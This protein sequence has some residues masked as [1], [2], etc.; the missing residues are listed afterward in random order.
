MPNALP[1]SFSTVLIA[2]IRVG[3]QGSFCDFSVVAMVIP[4]PWAE[5]HC[6]T[7]VDFLRVQSGS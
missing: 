1:T 3:S 5:D 6:P 2:T 4:E 7:E